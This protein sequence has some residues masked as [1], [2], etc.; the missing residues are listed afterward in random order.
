MTFKCVHNNYNVLDREKS[1]AFYKEALG[2]HIARE[3]EA[4]DGSFKLVYMADDLS[5]HQVELTW[6][7]DRTE[8]YDLGD[9]EIHIAFVADDFFGRKCWVADREVAN[10]DDAAAFVDEF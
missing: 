10:V 8:P 7:R 2:L 5:E 3:K 4:A 6:L 9:N 1:I